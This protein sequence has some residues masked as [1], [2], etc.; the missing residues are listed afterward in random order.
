MKKLIINLAPT[1]MIPT[2]KM[3]PHV[4]ESSAEIIADV[5]KC[6]PLGV[7]MAHL[8]ARDDKG[9]P[10]YKKEIYQEIITGIKEKNKE[11]IIVVSTSGRTYSEFSQR[12]DVLYLE[13]SS[14]PDMASLTLSSLNFNKITSINSPDMIFKLVE[15]MREKGIKPELEIFDLGM[16]NFAHYLIKKELLQ[17][18]YYFNILLGNIA[19]AQAKLLHLGLIISELPENSIWSVAGI[20]DSQCRMNAISII[21]GGGVRVGLEDNI[22]FDEERAILATNYA[23]VERLVKIATVVGR[24]IATS[25][26]VRELL[27]LRSLRQ[28][29]DSE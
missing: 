17:P 18:P 29:N 22:W 24:P 15:K 1:G 16:V 28:Q 20:G 19:A 11:L 23:L 4:P 27:K 13:G 6:A 8:H 12:S 21:D 9:A 14:K 5:L 2:K 3:T 26:E 7:S 25:Q 10:T